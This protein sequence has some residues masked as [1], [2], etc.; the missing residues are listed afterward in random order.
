MRLV[1]LSPVRWQSFAQRPHKFV[2]WF[3]SRARG[4]VLWVDPYPTRFPS[5]ADLRRL[6]GATE[7][8]PRA[9]PTWIEVIQPSALPLEPLP[10]SGWLNRYFWRDTITRVADFAASGPSM[11]VI[12]KPSVLALGMLERFAGGRTVYDAMDDFPAFYAGLSRR[13]MRRR[14][15]RVVRQVQVVMASST[16]LRERW[17][18]IRPDVVLVH[19]AMD[20][21]VLPQ[22]GQKKT[23][24]GA[25]TLGY[26][27]TIGSWFDW[28]WII[29][30]AVARPH[31]RIRLVGPAFSAPPRS[32]PA[33]V[34]MLPPCDHQAA[35]RQMQ[36]FD[37]GLIPF[38]QNSLTRSVDPIKYYEYRALGLPVLSTA[39][40]EMVFRG[41]EAG[42][43]ISRQ[44]TDT[45]G[46][47]EAALRYQASPGAVSDFIG[48]NSWSARFDAAGLF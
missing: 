18:A 30:L 21:A 11:L 45:A 39:F 34:E 29:T 38:K 24:D 12:G 8:P 48:S 9:V 46:L 47:V 27:G 13:A 23:T 6:G 2:E 42:T 43:F 1:Y 5:L 25:K 20:P 41:G 16:A 31:D 33:N 40:G 32:L 7:E 36:R 26:V 3:H 37:V 15:Q 28:D 4:N 14:E 10:L 22:T 35:L 17:R 44:R 19:N